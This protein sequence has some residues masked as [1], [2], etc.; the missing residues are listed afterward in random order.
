MTPVRPPIR[1]VGLTILRNASERVS[2]ILQENRRR[3]DA[4]EDPNTIRSTWIWIIGS[5]LS[6]IYFDPSFFVLEEAR[7]KRAMELSAARKG[8]AKLFSLA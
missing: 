8:G 2:E 6:F 1:E 5:S 7:R 3:L 4:G